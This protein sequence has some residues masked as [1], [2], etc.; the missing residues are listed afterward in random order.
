MIR[1][2]VFFTLKDTTP[3]NDALTGLARLGTI[4]GVSRFEVKP[5]AKA[6]LYANDIDLVVYAEFT[7][8]D[9][10]HA[11]KRHPT[12]AEVTAHVRPMRELRF[13]ADIETDAH[14]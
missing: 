9:A 14:A 1:H 6:D 4:P 7:G 12:Y 8:I 13:A 5:N 2:I 11:W 3:L 10:M